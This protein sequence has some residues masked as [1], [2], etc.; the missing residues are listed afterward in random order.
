MHTLP[1][2]HRLKHIIALLRSDLRVNVVFTVAPHAFGAG[3]PEHLRDEGI[4]V[5]PWKDAVRT[6]FDLALAAGSQGIDQIRAPLIRM[7]HGAGHIKLLR[8]VRDGE[9]RTPGLLSRRNLVRAGRVVPAAV[10]LSHERYLDVLADSCPEALP[11]AA[12]V[13]DPCHD[14]IVAGL[15]RRDAY[16]RAFGL[17]EGQ[18]LVTVTSTWGPSSAFGRLDALLPRLLGELPADRYRT[19]VLVHPNV[20][21]GHGGWQVRGWLAECRRRG[22]TLIPPDADW[23]SWLLGSD[24]I[25]GDHGSGTAYGSLTGVPILM[26]RHPGRDIA[27]DSPAAALAALA[28]ALS[29]AHPLPDQLRYAAE[30]Y[31]YEDYRRVGSLLT[32]EP[33]RFNELMRSLMYRLLGLGEPAFAPDTDPAPLPP[34]LTAWGP[35]VC[36]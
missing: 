2:A 17:D 27:S 7:S 19:A 23:E 18:R 4:T 28:P 5:V 12:V 29:P 22:V 13:G 34:R 8:R 15:P 6:E 9:P 20:W 31:R 33:G 26:A 36:P 10:A 3:V 35:G 32:S 25:I 1:Y 30:R 24:G 14:R 21:A 11:V 16:R